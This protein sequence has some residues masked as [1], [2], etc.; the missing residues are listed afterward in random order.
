MTNETGSNCNN[1]Q[2]L[3]H[4]FGGCGHGFKGFDG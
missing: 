1:M 2:S 3:K 4:R